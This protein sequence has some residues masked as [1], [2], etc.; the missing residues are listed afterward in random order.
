MGKARSLS[1]YIENTP[2]INST[3]SIVRTTS[4]TIMPSIDHDT[5]SSSDSDGEREVYPL[6]DSKNN[7]TTYKKLSAEHTLTMTSKYFIN[8][9]TKN[10]KKVHSALKELREGQKKN[11]QLK[12]DKK[13]SVQFKKKKI[14]Q[15]KQ[16]ETEKQSNMMEQRFITK[17]RRD[18]TADS[19]P[20]VLTSPSFTVSTDFSTEDEVEV[21]DDAFDCLD[22]INHISRKSFV[23]YKEKIPV[24]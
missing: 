1:S 17:P 19:S 14:L 12:H 23:A 5:S 4:N 8:D 13:N 22:T 21:G 2:I 10:K 24:T 11:N 18:P 16:K 9:L 15:K 7:A 3:T 20:N 6:I